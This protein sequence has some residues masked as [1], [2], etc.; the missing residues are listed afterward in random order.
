[1]SIS[2]TSVVA[3]EDICPA[4]KRLAFSFATEENGLVLHRGRRS[5]LMP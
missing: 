1:M 4:G 5:T 2:R 3:E